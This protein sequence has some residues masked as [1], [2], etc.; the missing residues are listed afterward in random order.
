MNDELGSVMISLGGAKAMAEQS[1]SERLKSVEGQTTEERRK[2][3]QDE[4]SKL[5]I[6]QQ[7]E[8]LEKRR[9]EV[10]EPLENKL[11]SINEKL[12]EK[13]SQLSAF[14]SDLKEEKFH[15]V[16]APFDNKF[17]PVVSRSNC[18]SVL[19][20]LAWFRGATG[21]VVGY[22]KWFTAIW[23]NETN[24]GFGI[25]VALNQIIP[26]KS[27]QDC[28]K[29]ASAYQLEPVMVAMEESR[30]KWVFVLDLPIFKEAKAF[31][32]EAKA[33]IDKTSAEIEELEQQAI[34]I[35]NDIEAENPTNEEV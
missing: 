10:I 7:R 4:L 16:A 8:L 27:Y 6:E 25:S 2:Y 3:L 14:Y 33:A 9:Q 11:A 29:F 26:I 32:D 20:W 12:S 15:L 5:D 1:I 21:Q 28:V 18:E 30:E 34:T 22:N 13:R 31:Y 35:Q 19:G 17:Q 24:T 23:C